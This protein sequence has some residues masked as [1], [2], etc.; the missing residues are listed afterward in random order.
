MSLQYILFDLD[1]TLYDYGSGLFQEVRSRIETWMVR[2]L[3]IS[4]EEVQ[5]LRH[6]YLKAY[7]TTLAG[8]IR[9]HPEADRDDYLD[10][11]HQVDVSRYLAPRPDLGAMLAALP[12]KKGIFT[13]GTADWA[14]RI[15]CQLGIRQYFG[16]LIDIRATHYVGKPWPE[17]YQMVLSILGCDGAECAFVDDQSRNLQP[18]AALGMR[19]VLVRPGGVPGDGVEF[20][21]N[22]ILDAG[23]VLRQIL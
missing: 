10:M 5:S 6:E 14:D 13:N 1:D 9:H 7:G 17:A 15:L 20:A 8:L 19:T 21:V 18:A 3:Q 4:L 11:V 12:V 23:V 2:A 16:P 22:D